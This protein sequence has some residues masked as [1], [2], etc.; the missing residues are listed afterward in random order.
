MGK[1]EQKAEKKNPNSKNRI[2]G[3]FREWGWG[4]WKIESSH[5]HHHSHKLYFFRSSIRRV[6]FSFHPRFSPFSFFS[7]KTRFIYYNYGAFLSMPKGLLL[8]KPKWYYSRIWVAYLNS[9]YICA[10]ICMV[11]VLGYNFIQ[12][13]AHIYY[14]Y[15]NDLFADKYLKTSSRNERQETFTLTYVHYTY[16]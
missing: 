10:N 9:T 13:I 11:W 12:I 6:F 4:E 14:M 2:I 3:C 7:V 16:I 5:H 15:I 1:T 8:I